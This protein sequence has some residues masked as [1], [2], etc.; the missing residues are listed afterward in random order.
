MAW[1]EMLAGGGFWKGGDV[2]CVGLLGW[3]MED[4]H[5]DL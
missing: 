2:G 1:A 3:E 4:L 5:A